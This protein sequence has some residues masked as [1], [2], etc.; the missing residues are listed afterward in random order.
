M[1][2]HSHHVDV[3]LGGIKLDMGIRISIADWAWNQAK[4]DSL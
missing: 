2:Y 3:S 1:L 4:A